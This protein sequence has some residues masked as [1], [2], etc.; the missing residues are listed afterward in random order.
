MAH[1]RRDRESEPFALFKCCCVAGERRMQ[2]TDLPGQVGCVDNGFGEQRQWRLAVRAARDVRDACDVREHAGQ[3]I[4]PDVHDPVGE[5]AL[6]RGVTG[7]RV[8]RIE[9]MTMPAELTRAAPRQ[10]NAWAP[11]SV[12]PKE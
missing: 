8:I 4:R 6:G 12:T 1:Q 10:V 2:R 5:A 7:V 3:D 9:A 11:A